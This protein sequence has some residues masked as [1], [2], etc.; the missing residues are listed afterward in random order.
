VAFGDGALPTISERAQPDKDRPDLLRIRFSLS[1]TPYLV[2]T[3][4]APNCI[5]NLLD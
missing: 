2:G 5:G 3:E 1:N 4:N